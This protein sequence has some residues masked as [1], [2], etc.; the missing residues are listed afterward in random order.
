M[1]NELAKAARQET[2]AALRA[3][4]LAAHR[5]DKLDEAK[6]LYRRY[7]ATEPGDAL[8][9]SNLGALLRKEGAHILA[10]AAQRRAYE[11]SPELEAV[12][13]NLANILAD[14]GDAGEALEL[15]QL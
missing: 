8:V 1:S 11:L 5:Q 7:L 15:R 4:A 2:L 3:K 10:R 6:E 9:W 12:R 14:L 13:A